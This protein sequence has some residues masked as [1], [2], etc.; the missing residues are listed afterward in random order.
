MPE[1]VNDDG[2][3]K[4]YFL[5]IQIITWRNPR[6][7]GRKST[8]LKLKKKFWKAKSESYTEDKMQGV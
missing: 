2:A 5:I 6:E 3:E 4:E 7:D 1:K 8:E